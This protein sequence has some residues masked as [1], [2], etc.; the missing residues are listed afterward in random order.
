MSSF[1]REVTQG[2]E[3]ACAKAV[4]GRKLFAN[5]NPMHLLSLIH[6]VCQPLAS[7]VVRFTEQGQERMST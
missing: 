4:K 5:I 3:T 6:R 1:P 2:R 7:K